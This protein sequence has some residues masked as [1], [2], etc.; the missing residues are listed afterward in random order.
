MKYKVKWLAV[1]VL[2]TMIF[3]SI[4]PAYGEDTV[5]S[6]VE[7]SSD[8]DLGTGDIVEEAGQAVET[9]EQGVEALAQGVEMLG[10]SVQNNVNNTIIS[11][12]SPVQDSGTS[13][14]AEAVYG[15]NQLENEAVYT[16]SLAETEAM[17][18]IDS[19]AGKF[20]EGELIVKYKSGAD[21]DTVAKKHGGKT[22][23]KVAKLRIAKVK[24]A[25]GKKFAE[26][27]L[28]YKNDPNVEYVEPDYIFNNSFLPSDPSYNLQW[29]LDSIKATQ[30]WD[31]TKGSASVVIAVADTG[32]DADHQDLV[33]NLV[34][35]YNTI[36]NTANTNDD[37]GHGTHVAGIS[38]GVINNGVGISGVAGECKI[39]PIKVLG[40]T[41]SGYTTDI[42]EGV[43]WAVD[44]GAKVI[45][46]SLG[47]STYVQAFQDAID[48]AYNNGVIVIAASGNNNTS[49]PHYPAAYNH[50]VAVGAVDTNHNK[51]SFSNYGSHVDIAAPGTS[52]YSTTYNGSYGYMQ[53]TSM[54]CPFVAGLA[55][56]IFSK[57][58]T[59][60][61]GQVENIIETTAI[62]LGTAGKDD[63]FGYGLIDAAA[64][65]GQEPDTT[66]ITMTIVG[67]T[68]DPFVPAGT[69]NARITY[70]LPENAYVTLKVYDSSNVLVR[71]LLSNAVK[72]AGTQYVDWNGKNTSG[73]IVAD[74]VYTYVF[75]LEDS[76]GNLST[77]VSGTITIDKIAPII[78][79]I[80]ISPDPFVPNEAN[81]TTISYTLSEDAKAT[82]SVYT[83]TN[84][85]VKTLE[86]AVSKSAGSNTVEWNG[87]NSAG[88]LVNDG[89]YVVKIDAVDNANIKAVQQTKS[90]NI[91]RNNSAFSSVSDSPDPFKVTGTSVNIIKFTALFN[92][93][94]VL[95]IYDSSNAE[96]RTLIN[97]PVTAGAKSITWNAKDNSG[98]IVPDGVYTYKLQAFDLSNNLLGETSGTITTDKT[99][100]SITNASVTPSTLED[101][102]AIT[103]AYTL[104]E[105]T[106]VTVG[107]YNSKNALVKTLAT[108]AAQSAGSNSIAW[109]GKIS[110]AFAPEGVYTYKITA[111]DY[112]GFAAVPVTGTFT[113]ERATPTIT[114]V[115]DAPD[116]FKM[117]GTTLN[118][119][120]YTLSEKAAVTLKIYDS[121]DTLVR[122]LVDGTLLPGALTAAW[123]GKDD[124]GN[125]V[126]DGMYT[127]K[128]N[129]TDMAGKT[130][131][132]VT[133]TIT[134]DKSTPAITNVA[135]TP[136][137]LTASGTVTI[138]YTLSE[139]A[140]VTVGIYKNSTVLVKTL[141]TAAAQSSGDNSVVWDAKTTATTLAPDDVYT[142]KITAVDYVGFASAP[143]T[144][145]FTVE[146]SNPTITSVSDTPDPFKATGTTL[147]TIKYTL[148]EKAVV[149]LKIYDSSNTLVK[150][151]VDGTLLPGA[152][153]VTWNGKDDLGSLVADGTYTYK[154]NATDL[155]GKTA[156]EAVG[157]IDIDKTAPVI[158][159]VSASPNPFVYVTST[160]KATI[161]YTL[162]ENCKVT[163]GIY[164]SSNVLVKTICT[165]TANNAGANAVYWYGK[166]NSN[167]LVA[168][169]TYTY[170]IVA[171]DKM[172]FKTETSGTIT[173]SR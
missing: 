70:T 172:S 24:L 6:I 67:D 84:A 119:I 45:N 159:S 149:T 110:T 17:Y 130:A 37:N 126:A 12:T 46:M 21:V 116:P 49:A 34:P 36:N 107:I 79:G 42:T 1:V 2:I 173:F 143:V 61:P 163:I 44:H 63:Y 106:K 8:T 62:D 147:C 154:I 141:V 39:M 83:A 157:T 77:P 14:V 71:T 81:T 7:V 148:S 94:V 5:E 150:T 97:G 98:V 30:A 10:E 155:A 104:S 108:S 50:V 167:I 169:G 69:N 140:K 93:T 103:V 156:V 43:I 113:I 78:S 129:A 112:V 13:T 55:G 18:S 90:F 99:V 40:S 111:V 160:D 168:A 22:S 114:S 131:V 23:K 135:A 158:S 123:N 102:G 48:Y 133:G 166:N 76:A 11:D 20:N 82:V 35:G 89:T 105:N 75:T 134:A 86:S 121:N 68:P 117:T 80:S 52:I 165:S 56:L 31:S 9:P 109:D 19:A 15:T 58:P 59:L 115:S 120:K 65:L 101:T 28:E 96:V 91:Q 41:G 85:L 95:K 146:R 38:A 3:S 32:V 33:A 127:Y 170:K 29:G 87:K 138:G 16:A 171:V 47:G 4:V 164:N 118:T 124:L 151:L 25:A 27:L 128:I 152:L 139:N 66:P 64:A 60:T 137:T 162:S 26:Q 142:Y 125:L 92:S 72:P 57:D 54:A 145:T 132:Q 100:P 144:G 136:G 161:N 153:S 51:A 122:T 53:G 74:G 73:T 88:N